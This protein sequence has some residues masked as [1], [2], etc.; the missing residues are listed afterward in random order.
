MVARSS[1][2]ASEAFPHGPGSKPLKSTVVWVAVNEL[3][4]NYYIEETILID[5]YIYIHPLW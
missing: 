4:L 1:V 2:N 5:I 3:K